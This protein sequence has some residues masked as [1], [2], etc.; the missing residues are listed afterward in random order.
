PMCEGKTRE[1]LIHVLQKVGLPTSCPICVDDVMKAVCHD[2]KKAE[3]GID[4]VIVSE[5]GRAEI[6]RLSLAEVRARIEACFGQ[7]MKERV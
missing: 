3:Q 5:I 2:K 1:K 7:G 6:V 4:C